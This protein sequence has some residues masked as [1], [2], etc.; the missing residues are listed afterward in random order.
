MCF[1]LIYFLVNSWS[2]LWLQYRQTK[3]IPSSIQLLWGQLIQAASKATMKPNLSIIFLE[4]VVSSSTSQNGTISCSIIWVLIDF[5]ISSPNPRL[6]C[7][8]WVWSALMVPV[9]HKIPHETRSSFENT[10]AEGNFSIWSR[11][12]GSDSRVPHFQWEFTVVASPEL[13]GFTVISFPALLSKKVQERFCFNYW[14]DNW[15]N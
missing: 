3:I 11:M 12:W 14:T 6:R 10:P 7:D 15:K 8:S 9:R 2:Q 13:R 1:Y 5:M 4:A